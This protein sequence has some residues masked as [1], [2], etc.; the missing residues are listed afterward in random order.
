MEVILV[1]GLAAFGYTEACHA[2]GAWVLWKKVGLRIEGKWQPSQWQI[3]SVF[4]T[5]DMCIQSLTKDFNRYKDLYSKFN[6]S[7]YEDGS[8]FAVLNLTDPSKKDFSYESKCLPD[9]VKPGK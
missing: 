8:G 3:D 2:E 5:Y 7:V 9:K 6:P 4:P 1:I